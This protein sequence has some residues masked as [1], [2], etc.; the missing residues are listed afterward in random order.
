MFLSEID[1][2]FVKIAKPLFGRE[3]RQLTFIVL[4]ELE[5]ERPEFG[6]SSLDDP[7]DACVYFFDLDFVVGYI[8]YHV[9][10][11]EIDFEFA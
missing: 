8:F 3:V 7:I 6:V 10:R 4:L 5:M 2:V 11:F 9:K 1:E